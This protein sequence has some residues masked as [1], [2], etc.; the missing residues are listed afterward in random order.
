LALGSEVCCEAPGGHGNV[1]RDDGH[2]F[3]PEI[4]TNRPYGDFERLFGASRLK[5]LIVDLAVRYH[6][7][8]GRIAGRAEQVW[9]GDSPAGTFREVAGS[10]VLTA[11]QP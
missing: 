8:H 3:R 7:H 10:L 2:G 6:E 1:A 9:D 11:T 4:E 5:L